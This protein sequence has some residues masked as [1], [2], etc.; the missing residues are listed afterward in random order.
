MSIL[1]EIK[2]MTEK[3]N[4]GL[5]DIQARQD[6]IEAELKEKK[7]PFNNE[8]LERMHKKQDLI[9]EKLQELLVEKKSG[10]PFA[11]EDKSEKK[12]NLTCT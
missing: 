11:G 3:V 10:I 8:E 5:H 12:F 4:K 6:E 1:E 2:T 7:T 9:E